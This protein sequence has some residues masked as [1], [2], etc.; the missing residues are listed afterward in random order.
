MALLDYWGPS[1]VRGPIEILISESGAGVV[2]AEK[3]VENWGDRQAYDMA[4]L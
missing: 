2:E 1:G 4:Y 3:L